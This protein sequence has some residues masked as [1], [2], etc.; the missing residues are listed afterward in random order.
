M[1]N[2]TGSPALDLAIGLAFIFFL[3]STLASAIHELIAAALGLRARTLE[4][5]LR[6]MLED[7]EKG[8]NLVD[9]FY[10]HDLI[11]SLYQTTS[12]S[13]E[14]A[15]PKLDGP[16][17]GLSDEVEDAR[18]RLSEA[19]TPAEKP[20]AAAAVKRTTRALVLVLSDEVKGRSSGAPERASSLP[21]VPAP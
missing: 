1:L 14:A 2:L 20:A 13:G 8:W 15:K 5:G 4:E 10:D 19:G 9:D 17:G 7:P 21:P 11:R 16:V 6:S 18:T 3:L 12:P